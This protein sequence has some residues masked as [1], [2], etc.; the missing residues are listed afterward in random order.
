M[1]LSEEQRISPRRRSA[2][3]SRFRRISS[4][5]YVPEIDGL[6]FLAIALVVLRHVEVLFS[7][8]A[9]FAVRISGPGRVLQQVLQHGDQGV[10]LF[11]AISGF[12]LALPFAKQHLRAG[13]PVSLPGYYWRRVTRLEPPYIIAMVFFF[14]MKV[15]THQAA[16]SDLLPHLAASLVYL[17]NIVYS[18]MSTITPIAWSLEVEVQFYLLAP[19]LAAVFTLRSGTR[20]GVLIAGILVSSLLQHALGLSKL[21]LLG[22]L[23]YFLVGFLALELRLARAT[24]P[25]PQIAADVAGLAALALLLLLGADGGPVA[26]AQPWLIL[27]IFWPVLLGNGAWRKV[28]R[29]EWI[30]VVG[31]MCYSIYLLHFALISFLGRTT[32]SIAIS[33]SYLPNVC[34]Q[35]ALLTPPILVISALY[36]RI[37]ERPCMVRDWPKRLWMRFKRQP[38]ADASPA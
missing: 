13:R 17:H 10:S 37:I 22:N 16:A 27:C 12:I 19:L 30:T 21:T 20:R 28:F 26:I 32:F 35:I 2:F 5:E 6:R 3:L 23:Q 18:T 4:I 34:F 1:A 14:A 15:V 8:R 24:P 36:F 31:G 11:F 33:E 25:R 9:T 7:E 29:I 38:S